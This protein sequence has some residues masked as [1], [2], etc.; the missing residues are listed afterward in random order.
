[1]H[2]QMKLP[3]GLTKQPVRSPTTHYA[4]FSNPSPPFPLSLDATYA[5]FYPSSCLIHGALLVCFLILLSPLP[6]LLAQSFDP[7]P[8]S[9]LG[10]WKC[11]FSRV[12]RALQCCQARRL[13]PLETG[14]CRPTAPLPPVTGASKPNGERQACRK[15]EAKTGSRQECRRRKPGCNPLRAGI[16]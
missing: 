9:G 6:P 13:P 2:R 8:S 15:L 1:M 4:L 12:L 10:A 11:S 7:T 3:T 5:I 16:C 14:D